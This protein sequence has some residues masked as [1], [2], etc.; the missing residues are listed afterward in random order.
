[1]DSSFPRRPDGVSD[2]AIAALGKLSEALETVEQA[3]GHLYAMHQLIGRANNMLV[4]AAEM[5][6][7]AELSE[8]AARLRTEIIG[9]NIIDGRWTFQVVEEFDDGYWTALRS[10]DESARDKLVNG[11]RHIFEAEMKQAQITPG[12]RG[13]EETPPERS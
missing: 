2:E 8:W 10:F 11:V 7:E 9:L 12:R 1:M 6:D 5:F 13:H 3:R 4:D